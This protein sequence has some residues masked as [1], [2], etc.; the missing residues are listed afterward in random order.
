MS[1]RAAKQKAA[2]PAPTTIAARR[3]WAEGDRE[4]DAIEKT[5]VD[6][7]NYIDEVEKAVASLHTDQERVE[8]LLGPL[9]DIDEPGPLLNGG[10]AEELAPAVAKIRE[11]L[12]AVG[13]VGSLGETAYDLARKAYIEVEGVDV[14]RLRTLA[15]ER[16][17]EEER[18][19]E[20]EAEVEDLEAQVADGL[21][22]ED[23]GELLVRCGCHEPPNGW[24]RD[25][26]LEQLTELAWQVSL[27]R[28]KG[29]A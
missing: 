15:S 2:P 25:N 28:S 1:R 11:A 10:T 24:T 29:A 3:G 5:L 20:A 17:A 14:A 23:V 8:S 12:L 9:V 7:R 22:P 27:A 6:V 13:T 19:Q 26:V 18:A 21:R 16:D 4:A